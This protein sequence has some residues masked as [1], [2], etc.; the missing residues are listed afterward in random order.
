MGS[1]NFQA[2]GRDQ[3][4]CADLYFNTAAVKLLKLLADKE[5]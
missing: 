5:T 2:L 4:S 3:T 1:H